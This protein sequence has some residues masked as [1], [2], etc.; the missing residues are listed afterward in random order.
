MERSRV[1]GIPW[2]CPAVIKAIFLS[3]IPDR[4]CGCLGSPQPGPSGQ[5][6]QTRGGL[7]LSRNYRPTLALRWW[8]LTSWLG[9]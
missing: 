9:L 7:P 2:A 8:P 4:Q 5:E 6:P 1:R 3:T